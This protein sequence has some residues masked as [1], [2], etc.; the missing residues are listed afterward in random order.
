[1]DLNYNELKAEDPNK[2]GTKC[3]KGDPL[4]FRQK[5]RERAPYYGAESVACN[6]CY[7]EAACYRGY[8]A[9]E[10]ADKDCDYDICQE[11]YRGKK[12]FMK[13]VT[14][15]SGDPLSLRTWNAEGASCDICEEEIDVE[16][17]E[18]FYQCYKNCNYC[19]C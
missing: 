16:A 1:M 7:K 19:I 13:G 12:A 5:P 2:M 17:G 10:N 18:G 11:C 14:C 15:P 6:I 8:Y 3:D 9:C 4:V